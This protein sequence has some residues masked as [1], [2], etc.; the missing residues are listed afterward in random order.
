VYRVL[1]T[2]CGS[3]LA[4]SLR[5]R[6]HRRIDWPKTA[7]VSIKYKVPGSLGRSRLIDRI[8]FQEATHTKTET[9][10]RGAKI[11]YPEWFISSNVLTNVHSPGRRKTS[12]D[13]STNTLPTQLYIEN[14]HRLLFVSRFYFDFWSFKM[15]KNTKRKT[16]TIIIVSKNFG[17]R[18]LRP[19]KKHDFSVLITKLQLYQS[20]IFFSHFCCIF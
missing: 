18:F 14:S 2:H 17:M 8:F 13:Y 3:Q 7:A 4:A 12:W 6:S 11:L 15:R 20:V 10:V 1:V 16:S 5:K 9:E 19:M